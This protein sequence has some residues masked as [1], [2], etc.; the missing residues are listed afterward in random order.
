MATA[1]DFNLFLPK[2]QLSA[3]IQAI[4]SASVSAQEPDAI[5][6]WLHGDACSGIVFNLGGP[7]VL[8]DTQF[9]PGVIALPV[10]K[11]A[12]LLTLAPDS[13]LVGVRFH[14]AVSYGALGKLYEQPTAITMD[15]TR[16]LALHSLYNQLKDTR[17]QYA[18]LVVLYR[19]LN[20]TLDTFDEIPRSLSTVLN[21]I[22][23]EKAIGDLKE[24]APVSQ[25]HV[26]RQFQQWMDMTPK[27][28]QRLL[29]VKNT[30][31][32]LRHNPTIELAEL[33][34]DKGFAD[35]AHMTRE[36]KH[37]AKTTPGKFCKMVIGDKTAHK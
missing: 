18:R 5:N 30:L 20:D 32:T 33:A 35:Q 11:L 4:W 34:A 15:A 37:I 19:W 6:R 21:T 8:N 24:S 14:L 1:F 13:Q 2:G 25:R 3:Q 27:Y 31:T 22:N 17:G 16:P 23:E 26:E 28:Y 29:R 36:F 12:Q 7:I 10:S 9:S